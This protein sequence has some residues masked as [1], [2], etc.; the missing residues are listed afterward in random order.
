MPSCAMP[1]FSNS[2]DSSH[3]IQCD[4][5][6]M[7]K[8]RPIATAIEPT[9]A[10]PFNYDQIETR[11]STQASRRSRQF[12]FCR[13]FGQLPAIRDIARFS[14]EFARE[15]VPLVDRRGNG[16]RAVAIADSAQGLNAGG[17]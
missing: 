16:R 1:R 3:M 12:E 8:A 9:L 5:P 17:V 15:A 13:Q 6:Y 4:I 7:R 11:L 2:S 14:A 10:M